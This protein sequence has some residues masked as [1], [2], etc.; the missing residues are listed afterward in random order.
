MNAWKDIRRKLEQDPNRE[1]AVRYLADLRDHAETRLPS[2]RRL[3]TE[4]SESASG[5]SWEIFES[6]IRDLQQRLS[7]EI[8]KDIGQLRT[9]TVGRMTTSSKELDDREKSTSLYGFLD[10]HGI[11]E[12]SA[13]ERIFEEL[14]TFF[15]ER[16]KSLPL[17]GQFR[18]MRAILQSS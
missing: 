3:L 18:A 1:Y 13:Q 6:D 9:D 10:R 16:G 14:S 12:T 11:R 15:H 5:D 7:G 2:A 8:G 4:H 17:S